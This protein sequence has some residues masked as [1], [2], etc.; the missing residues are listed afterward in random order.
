MTPQALVAA[1]Q[2]GDSAFPSGAFTQSYGLETLVAEHAVSNAAEVE[3]MLAAHLRHRLARADLPA[4][5][6]AHRAAMSADTDVVT[7]IDL[8]LTAVK[9]TREERRA[10][11][12]MGARLLTEARR[13]APHAVLDSSPSN[14]AVAFALTGLAMGLSGRESAMTYAYG[15]ASS[16]ASASMRLLRIGHGDAQAVLRRSGAT[17]EQAVDYAETVPWS[18]L[19]P[20]APRLEM[21]SA[22][23]ER[24]PARL[25]AS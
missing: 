22:R 19:S 12:R 1:L 23:H 18:A 3:E 6:A 16:F 24:L 7:E 8:A 21:A 2:L 20:F 13:L 10:S 15:F 5:L 25:F 9:M 11:H 4:L 14:A 17:I